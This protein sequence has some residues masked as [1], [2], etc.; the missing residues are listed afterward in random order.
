M[1]NDLSL[2]ELHEIG[3]QRDANNL[4]LL[5]QLTRHPDP[6][7]RSKACLALGWLRQ[8]RIIPPLIVCVHDHV[9]DVRTSA[10]SALMLAPTFSD[11]DLLGTALLTDDVPE[12]RARAARCIGFLRIK[13][14][15]LLCTAL[16]TETA[17]DVLTQIA[18][19]CRRTGCHD[20]NDS[21]WALFPTAPTDLKIEIM[22]TVAPGRADEVGIA[23]QLKASD[24]LLRIEAIRVMEQTQ[25][26][27]LC[28]QATALLKDPNPG[29]RCAIYIALAKL[30]SPE[31]RGLIDACE[32]DPHPEVRQHQL[33][34]SLSSAPDT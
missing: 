12:V 21:L 14:D 5:S 27:A 29:V 9:S 3:V 20:A 1:S 16:T 2:E 32:P 24:P 23:K 31:A 19:A 25:S 22:R 15:A 34:A 28:R 13:A 7:Y 11:I 17:V 8:S 4:A 10:L 18:Y 26:T 33:Q 6:A 30:D